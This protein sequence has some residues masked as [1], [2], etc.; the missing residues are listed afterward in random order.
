VQHATH[1]VLLALGVMGSAM[2]SEMPYGEKVVV[3]VAAGVALLCHA[4]GYA[5]EVLLNTRCRV[6]VWRGMI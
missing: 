1:A 5:G 6:P 2:P 4:V 3:G